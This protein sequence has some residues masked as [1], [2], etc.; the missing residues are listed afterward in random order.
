MGFG[1]MPPSAEKSVTGESKTFDLTNKS[2]LVSALLNGS[3]TGDNT[4]KVNIFKQLEALPETDPVF[5]DE[6]VMSAVAMSKWSTE[7][8]YKM[9][10]RL[11]KDRYF[12]IKMVSEYDD[13]F[14]GFADS[15][16][17]KDQE[18]GLALVKAKPQCFDK[19]SDELQ[20]NPDFL[21]K[22]LRI[23]PAVA[24]TFLNDRHKGTERLLQM[25]LKSTN[26]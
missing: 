7:P 2:M 11:K 10:P 8:L 15:E 21:A 6:E 17:L 22:A 4:D 26:Q 25:F 12:I 13:S 18:F 1:D 19:L 16:L 14:L 23:N 5:D 3:S 24:N 9:S 20:D